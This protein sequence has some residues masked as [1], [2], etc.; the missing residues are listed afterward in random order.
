[1]STPNAATTEATKLTAKKRV[2]DLDKFEKVTKEVQYEAP[3]ALTDVSQLANIESARLLSLVNK[4]LS[5]EALMNAKNSIEGVSTSLI[6]KFI[7]GF[8]MLPQFATSKD[9]RK[10]QTAEVLS[11]IRSFPPIMEQLKAAALA[12]TPEDEENEDNEDE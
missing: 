6:M 1:M 4:G 5:R 7:A 3:V 12:S 2:F 11:F 8:R 9:D 10:K